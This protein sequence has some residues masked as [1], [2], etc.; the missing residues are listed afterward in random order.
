MQ[1]KGMVWLRNA[2]THKKLLLTLTK[3]SKK[4]N[5]NSK[6]MNTTTNSSTTPTLLSIISTPQPNLQTVQN[7]LVNKNWTGLLTQLENMELFIGPWNIE[8]PPH[9]DLATMQLLM[10]L[11]LDDVDSA[12]A[13]KTRLVTS[14]GLNSQYQGKKLKLVITMYENLYQ[15]NTGKTLLL[16]KEGLTFCGPDLVPVFEELGNRL[17]ARQ[18]ALIQQAYITI[19]IDA[20]AE[21]LGI[22]RDAVAQVCLVNQWIVDGDFVIPKSQKNLTSQTNNNNNNNNNETMMRKLELEQQMKRLVNDVVFLEKEINY[23]VSTTS[24]TT[25]TKE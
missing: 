5:K 14:G 19:R 10:Y 25:S 9:P 11:L 24:N 21:A 15:N 7:H 2:T 8:T 3:H 1:R 17:Y 12:K 23:Q 6:T 22:N 4:K 18:I 16:I 20:V 13:L